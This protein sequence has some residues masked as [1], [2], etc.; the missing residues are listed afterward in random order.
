MPTSHKIIS[1][2]LNL[3]KNMW[4]IRICTMEYY[5]TLKK[6]EIMPFTATCVDLKIIILSKASQRKTNI[7]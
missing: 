6:N 4:Y 3:L 1:L 7:R 2:S 5:S